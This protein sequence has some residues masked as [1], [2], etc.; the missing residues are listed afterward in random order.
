MKSKWICV[1]LVAVLG[2]GAYAATGPARA[3]S[4]GSTPPPQPTTKLL[5]QSVV[6]ALNLRAHTMPAN[7]WRL[8]LRT[9]GLSD[10]Y[11]VDNAFAPGASTDWHSH[12]GPS[13]VFVVSGSVTNH[14]SD[15]P[16]CA[17]HAYKTGESFVDEGG[18]HVHK[19]VNA[20]GT[21]PA[22][23][24]AVQILPHGAPR[25]TTADEPSG[26]HIG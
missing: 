11:V 9:R 6:G 14:S 23:T 24:I 22:E 18:D 13:L 19:L 8:A 16:G 4:A 5:A 2:T 25:K 7:Q 20:S 26:C 1:L 10:T 21:L 3:Q 12:P 15:E 17:G